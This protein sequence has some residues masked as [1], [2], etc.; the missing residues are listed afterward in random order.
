MSAIRVNVPIYVPST[1]D[2]GRTCVFATVKKRRVA[3]LFF[4]R[5]FLHANERLGVKFTKLI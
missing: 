3:K 4:L 2:S 1:Y 5:I